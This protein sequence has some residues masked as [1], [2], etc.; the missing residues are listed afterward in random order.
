VSAAR[1]DLGFLYSLP[2]LEWLSL[3]HGRHRFKSRRL[4]LRGVV[5]LSKGAT[6]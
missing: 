5:V 6:R 2:A 4:E 3:E 1:D